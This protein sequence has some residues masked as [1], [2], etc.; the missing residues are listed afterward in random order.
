MLGSDNTSGRQWKGLS[1]KCLFMVQ[2]FKSEWVKIDIFSPAPAVC[3]AKRYG[4]HG[5]GRGGG[6]IIGLTSDILDAR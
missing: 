6:S 4:P 2:V 1:C 3:Y 5:I